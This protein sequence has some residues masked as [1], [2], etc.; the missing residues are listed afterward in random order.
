MVRRSF[1]INLMVL[2]HKS[3]NVVQ[4]LGK[5]KQKLFAEVQVEYEHLK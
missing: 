3:G 5:N 1:P 4:R 2:N